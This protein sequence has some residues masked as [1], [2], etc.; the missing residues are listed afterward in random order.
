MASS[1]R[2]H[3]CPHD[4]H[5]PGNHIKQPEETMLFNTIRYGHLII[6]ILLI[7]SLNTYAGGSGDLDDGI[8]TDDKIEKY[9]TL[10]QPAINIQYIKRRAMAAAQQQGGNPVSGSGDIAIGSFIN[11]PGAEVGDVIIIFDGEDINAIS[12]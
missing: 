10:G 7:T 1:A 12:E 8:G 2:G 11:Q 3:G 4:S 9:D 6:L 5:A